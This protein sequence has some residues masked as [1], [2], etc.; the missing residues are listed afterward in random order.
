MVACVLA[1]YN[2]N[3]NTIHLRA[4]TKLLCYLRNTCHFMIT[5][6]K[7]KGTN[8]DVKVLA[9]DLALRALSDASF[10]DHATG[11][12]TTGYV[13]FMNGGPVVWKSTL[14]RVV[15]TSSAE[16]EYYALSEC[17]KSIVF[18]RELLKELG[19]I[20]Q[21]PT[22]LYTD[23]ASAMFIALNPGF[24]SKSRSIRTAFH[25]VR[26]SLRL[27]EAMLI[28]VAGEENTAD[29]MTKPLSRKMTWFHCKAMFS[30]IS[31]N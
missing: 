27:N 21:Q 26:T 19:L 17:V 8:Q 29:I 12:S 20:F 22:P 13:M 4:V 14:Q 23:S 5:Y 7:R 9:K 3:P 18:A 24:T 31:R 2:S 10:G 25:N 16:S 6:S 15:A 30:N 11:R 28:K 1:R